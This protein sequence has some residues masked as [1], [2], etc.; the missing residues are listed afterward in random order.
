MSLLALLAVVAA[1]PGCGSS[2]APPT[3]V[4]CVADSI[5]EPR[6]AS[7]PDCAPGSG[8]AQAT[9]GS[10]GSG[11]STGAGGAQATGGSGGSTGG[12]GAQATGGS[13][14]SE[15]TPNPPGQCPCPKES[16]CDLTTNRCV[17]GCSAD[18]DCNAG[19]I[20]NP[21]RQCVAGCRQDAQCPAGQICPAATLVCTPGCRQDSDCTG[22]LHDC[23]TTTNTCVPG[24]AAHTDCPLEQVCDL[25]QH[26]CTDGCNTGDTSNP[27]SR[28]PVG[29]ACTSDTDGRTS[30]GA[31]C[32]PSA[33]GGGN[34][35]R[36][37]STAMYA[38]SDI[39]RQCR[40]SC[41]NAA[42]CPADQ[43]CY[44]GYTKLATPVRYCGPR[45]T[46]TN[47]V[48]GSGFVNPSGTGTCVC[49]SIGQCVSPTNS[50]IYCQ[51]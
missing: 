20:C 49:I 47:G 44:P 15:G 11:G 51:I 28:C 17:A 4:S 13:T 46:A 26:T 36:S 7:D 2:P 38:C 6:C 3:G 23:D 8:G 27:A 32:I 21:Q 50:N 22:A 24:C 40:R 39:S 1:Q 10:G 31:I 34:Q 35:C 19:R 9:G 29:T 33:T 45:C 18:G 5:C 37:D 41:V 12:G 25:T 14:G 43:S 16:Y 42:D 48:C 30:C